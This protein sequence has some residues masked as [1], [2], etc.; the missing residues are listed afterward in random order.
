MYAHSLEAIKAIVAIGVP[1]PSLDPLLGSLGA[2]V[3]G[4]IVRG[5]HQSFARAARMMLMVARADGSGQIFAAPM[6]TSIS[7]ST[8]ALLSL[9]QGT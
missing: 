2:T 3:G 6:P 7:L 4:Q 1:P 5:R 8:T 9:V